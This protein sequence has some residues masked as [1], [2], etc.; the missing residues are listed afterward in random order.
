[1]LRCL[2]VA[3]KENLTGVSTGL[4]GQ[5]KNLDPTG[6]PTGRS[7]QPVSSSA[8]EHQ[9][10]KTKK[11]VKRFQKRNF[12]ILFTNFKIAIVFL[13]YFRKLKIAGVGFR[14]LRVFSLLRPLRRRHLGFHYLL[15][16]TETV[17]GERL[18]IES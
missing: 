16:S 4:T 11:K 3:R 14:P 1:M 2:L 12:K 5:S 7:T 13:K 10:S 8:V 18:P 15:V 6:N 9:S 17:E